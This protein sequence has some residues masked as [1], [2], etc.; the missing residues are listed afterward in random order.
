MEM[1]LKLLMTLTQYKKEEQK[2]VDL[3]LLIWKGFI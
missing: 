2:I 3:T 1:G